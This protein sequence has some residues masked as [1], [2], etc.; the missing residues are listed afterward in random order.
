[1]RTKKCGSRSR[2][3]CLDPSL[4]PGGVRAQG[5]CEGTHE[6]VVFSTVLKDVCL[7]LQC[8][9]CGAMGTVNDPSEDEWGEAFHAPS[10]PYR[11]EHDTRVKLRGVG[12]PNIVRATSGP[13][14]DCPARRGLPEVGDYERF[15]AS[16]LADPGIVSDEERG[17]LSE[18]ADFVQGTDLCSLLL[19][20]FIRHIEEASGIRHP[21]AV[22]RIMDRIE[23]I[24]SK[25][26]HS[27][28]GVV[29]KVLRDFAGRD[30]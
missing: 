13:G 1:M 22:G 16:L 25:G 29:A 5:M 10:R 26:L 23:R 17:V 19:P 27:S 14:C 21:A 9:E 8:A 11:W 18:L 6:W 2:T 30:L 7:M 15:P 28:P 12:A 20:N 3:K 24:D 4:P